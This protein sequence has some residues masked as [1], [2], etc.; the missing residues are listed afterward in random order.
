MKADVSIES[1]TSMCTAL[2]HRQVK[3]TAHL[4]ESGRSTSRS[5]GYDG[6]GTK[7]IHPNASERRSGLE[8]ILGQ[9][10]HDLCKELPSCF[11]TGNAFVDDT[12]YYVMGCE[13]HMSSLVLYLLMKVLYDEP[14][15]VAV[16]RKK[17][18]VTTTQIKVGSLKS[19]S[20][21]Y[22][23]IIEKW[24]KLVKRAFLLDGASVFLVEF[25]VC[26]KA[27]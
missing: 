16:L 17:Y 9:V 15:N 13:C 19:A 6:P 8:S 20:S 4:L 14:G 18:W 23:V 1:M 11:L 7:H 5:S 21:H 2:V 12:S 3:I 27:G 25:R 10:G 26:F 22:S 24:A